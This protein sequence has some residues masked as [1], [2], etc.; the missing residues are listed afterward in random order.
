MYTQDGYILTYHRLPRG[1]NVRPATLHHNED[2]KLNLQ[3]DRTP[4]NTPRPPVLIM[5]GLMQCSEAWWVLFMM[6]TLNG[7]CDTIDQGVQRGLACVHNGGQRL[8]RMDRK[9][10]VSQP[11]SSL[12]ICVMGLQG[13]QVRHEACWLQAIQPGGTWRL[14]RVDFALLNSSCSSGIFPLTSLPDSTYRQASTTSST[15]LV[16]PYTSI[17]TSTHMIGAGYKTLTYIG[18]SQGSAQAFACFS[19]L[20]DVANKACSTRS[21]HNHHADNIIRSICSSRCHRQPRPRG[22]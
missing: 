3:Q 8:R 18:F 15:S 21:I 22:S 5:H 10:P 12:I 13:Q 17:I 9:Q 2:V 19:T 16:S 1:K 6:L 4:E 11:I 20:P 14:C 7:L